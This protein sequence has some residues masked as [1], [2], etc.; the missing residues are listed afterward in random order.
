MATLTTRYNIYMNKN[1]KY[2]F[3]VA[4]FGFL[5]G[6]A[7]LAFLGMLLQW[8]LG[9]D[10]TESYGIH[11]LLFLFWAVCAVGQHLYFKHQEEKHKKASSSPQRLLIPF[12]HSAEE[13]CE[14][15]VANL[16]IGK[17]V[18]Q[19]NAQMKSQQKTFS[20]SKKEEWEVLV[21]LPQ[22]SNPI[23]K[24][25]PSTKPVKVVQIVGYPMPP[26][27][28]PPKELSVESEAPLKTLSKNKAKTST[29]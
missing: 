13:A 24:L 15:L 17:Q 7:L 18:E 6:I 2:I 14:A 23:D 8:T 9:I 4:F 22:V 3:G 25:A 29:L 20:P 5:Y 1:I 21:K 27:Q 16:G 12:D 11:R 26:K 10:I 19:V 28:E